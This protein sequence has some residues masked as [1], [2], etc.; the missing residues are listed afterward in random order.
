MKDTGVY[1]GT[2]GYIGFRVWDCMKHMVVPYG[3]W[4]KGYGYGMSI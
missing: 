1:A 4:L 3:R 2:Q